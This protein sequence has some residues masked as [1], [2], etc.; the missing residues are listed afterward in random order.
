MIVN[1]QGVYPALLTPFKSDDT[2]DFNLFQKNLQA[3]VDAGID[4]AVLSGSLGEASTVTADEKRNL[5][6]AAK[7][8]V[9][10]S[11]PVIINVA[12]Q[13]TSE[14]IKAAQSAERD[15][16]DGLMLLP[17]MRY[18]ADERETV[19][20]FKSIAASTSLPIMLYNNPYDY[21]IE[22]TID[23][24]HQLQ[25]IATI[26]AVKNQPAMFLMLHA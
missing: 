9:G 1:W 4:G 15:G 20:Y 8:L 10:D 14:A 5:L 12:E 18:K 25:D 23:M 13:S 21:K 3:Q 26:Q 19:T 17:P 16:A 11:I 24:F 7:E 6:I 2:I 22:V